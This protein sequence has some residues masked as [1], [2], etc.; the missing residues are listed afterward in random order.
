MKSY[1]SNDGA[2]PLDLASALW[3]ATSLVINMR[4]LRCPVLQDR[5]LLYTAQMS[6]KALGRDYGMKVLR[7]SG[8][9]TASDLSDQEVD[10]HLSFLNAKVG[11]NL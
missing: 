3:T 4:V 9:D 8:R 10:S 11:G 1:K 5:L 7:K 6:I 2:Q